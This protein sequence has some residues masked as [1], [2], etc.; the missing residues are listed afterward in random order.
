MDKFGLLGRTLGHSWSPEIHALLG[1][2]DYGLYEVEPDALGDFLQTT[3]LSGLNV[4]IPYKKAVV[5]YCA[6]LSD[7]ARRIGSV[8]TLVKTANGWHGDNTDYAG[9][10]AMA[11][12]CGVPLAGKKALVFGSG[13]ASLSVIAAPADADVVP[14]VKDAPVM[15]GVRDGLSLNAFASLPLI[16]V[17]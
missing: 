16:G 14:F 15:D 8:N 9:F 5:P 11:E 17:E 10:I 13:G 1:G 3:E 12:R 2:Y 4:T 6:D 7:A